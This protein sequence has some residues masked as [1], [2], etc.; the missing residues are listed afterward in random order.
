MPSS[1]RRHRAAPA[2]SPVPA[3]PT[4]A[5][6]TP[7]ASTPP[8]QDVLLNFD[9]PDA[10]PA[11]AT[12]PLT[13]IQQFEY[14]RLRKEG[15]GAF[16][17]G[18]FGGALEA[19][20]QALAN[21][22]PSHDFAIV[23]LLNLAMTSLKLGDTRGALEYADRGLGLVGTGDLLQRLNGNTEEKRLLEFWLKLMT[24]RAEA[25]E[26]L[27]R[28]QQA[29]EAYGMVVEK[30]GASKSVMDGKRRCQKVVSPE[31]PRPT[32]TPAPQRTAPRPAPRPAASSGGLERVQAQLKAQEE[33]DA[34]KFR[35]H[36]A[37]AARIAAWLGGKEDDMRALLSTLHQILPQSANW[38]PVEAG[39]LVLPKKVRLVYMKAVARTHPDKINKSLPV[40]EQ[41]L[42]EQVFVK[43]NS[44]WDGFCAANGLS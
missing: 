41:L 23:V 8:P 38:A 10:A 24:R 40:E 17:S 33:R 35:L 25:L 28:W 6:S 34:A 2:S 18:D 26:Q 43:L 27:E 12:A 14:A 42:M 30:G 36:D 9:G 32:P 1:S 21:L 22:P 31:A 15:N 5:A 16:Q 7:A 29:L 39:A 13:E 19:Y 11:R 4:L 44:A 3:V 37:L 20:Q